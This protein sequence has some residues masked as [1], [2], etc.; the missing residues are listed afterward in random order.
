M[1]IRFVAA[2]LG[3]LMIAAPAAQAQPTGERTE[4]VIDFED[5]VSISEARAALEP[6]GLVP[7][8]NSAYVDEDG[9]YRA[10]VDRARLSEV[11]R[12]LNALHRVEAAD[13]NIEMRALFIPNDPLYEQQWGLRR[14]GTASAWDITC[15]R[16]VTVAVID[17]GVACENHGEFTRL[18]DLAGTRCLPGW[19]FVAGTAHANDDHGHGTHVAGT[20]AQTTHNALGGAGVAYCASILPVKVL[21]AR[22]RGTLANVAEGIRWAADHGAQVINLSLGGGGRSRVMARAVAYARSRGATVICAAGNNG[23]TVE[24]PANEAGAVAVSAIDEGDQIAFFSSRG[25][26]IDLAAPG[27]RIL[28]QT[29]CENGRNRCEQF[30]AWSGTSMAAPHVAGAAALLVSLGVSDPDAVESA[31][32]IYASQPAHGGSEPQLYGAGIV[33]G[34]LAAEGVLWKM[35]LT[36][37]AFLALLAAVVA[38]RIRRKHGEFSWSWL[39]PAFVTGVGGFFLP[40]FVSHRVPGVDFAMRPAASWDLL[41]FGASWHP[42]LPFAHMGIAL[43]L[44]GVGFSR[45]FLRGPIAGVSLGIASFLLG[46]AWMRVSFAPLGVIP[47]LAWALFNALVCLWIARIGIDRK[48]A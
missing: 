12:R 2:L 43:A 29:I 41:L 18:A 30:A 4:V 40:R 22:G 21:D 45:P 9:V 3:A 5:G 7:V 6:L 20:I 17:T 16:G 38:W 1:K 33:S 11:L 14:V 46:E 25:P 23:R 13:E 44:V 10:L 24:S 39:V 19:N 42:W 26:E 31:L 28:Q 27:V 32:K 35:G 48:T 34:A 37:L 15:G 47:F 36:R 8:A